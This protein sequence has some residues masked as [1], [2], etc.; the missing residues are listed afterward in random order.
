M[1]EAWHQTKA[2]EAET[3]RQAAKEA[4]EAREAL[5]KAET[6]ARRLMT[7]DTALLAKADE[8]GLQPEADA[9]LESFRARRR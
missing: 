1:D 4:T 7:L 6:E 8:A 3:L 9:V 2:E 5:K